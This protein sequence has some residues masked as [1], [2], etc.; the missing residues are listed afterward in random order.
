MVALHHGVLHLYQSSCDM[1]SLV[2]LA[3]SY[4]SFTEVEVVLK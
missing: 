3:M 4:V 2:D 1:P